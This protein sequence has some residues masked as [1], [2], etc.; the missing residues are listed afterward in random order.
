VTCPY[1]DSEF[2]RPLRLQFRIGKRKVRCCPICRGV[3]A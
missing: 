3:L 1:C 2:K